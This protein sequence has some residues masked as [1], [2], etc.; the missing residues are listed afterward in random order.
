MKTYSLYY[1][2]SRTNGI[3]TL[4]NHT[5]PTVYYCYTKLFT[6]KPQIMLR[7][8]AGKTSPMV[9]FA[10][11]QYLSKHLRIGTGDFEKQP[12]SALT[13]EEVRRDHVRLVRSDYEFDT[14]IGT[15]GEKKTYGWARDKTSFTNTVYHCVD[16]KGDRV[17]SLKSGGMFNFR[18]GA[19]IDIAEG[20]PKQ[21]EELLIVCAL[22]IWVAEAGWSVFKGYDSHKGGEIT[23]ED[24]AAQARFSTPEPPP[25]AQQHDVTAKTNEAHLH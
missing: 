25:T 22:G 8:G 18:K 11:V 14:N 13:H 17:A 7:E 5:D 6:M 10:R 1:T 21:H 23:A 19:E 9:A 12:E 16:E 2:S 3:L 15:N 4:G 20:L 24:P